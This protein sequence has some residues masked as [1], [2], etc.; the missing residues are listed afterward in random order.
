MK[1]AIALGVAILIVLGGFYWAFGTP[2][3]EEVAIPTSEEAIARGEYLTHAGGCA[4]CHQLEEAEGMTGGYTIEVE[5]PT[6]GT[7]YAPNITPDEETGIG[8]WTGR[9]FLL[10]M[11]HGRS[12]DGSFYWPA[13]PYR[14]YVGATDEDILAIAAYLMAQPAIRNEVPDHDLPWW[15]FRWLMA[16]WNIAADLLEGDY[17]ELPDDPQI[18]RGAYLA[19]NLGHC[20]ECHTPRNS[21]G[22]MELGNEF[23]GSETVSAQIDPEGLSNWTQE[24][25]VAFLE[26]GMT[27]S[28][29]FVGGE[30]EEVIM[31]NT[32]QLTPEDREAMAAFFT[33]DP[34]PEPVE[35]QAADEEG[36]GH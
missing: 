18:Q 34:M 22:M 24:D 4:R 3:V 10:A 2:E 36:G 15:Q 26:L 35:E 1:K 30:M 23:A 29:D 14:S 11:K 13:F 28:F 7:F 6:V 9:D 16:G 25:F 5:S 32:S 19:R 27:A 20:G 17:P 31:D 21:L 8:G 12:P 33:R